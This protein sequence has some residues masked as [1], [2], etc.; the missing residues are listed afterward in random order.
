MPVPEAPYQIIGID[1]CG[2][3]IESYSGNTYLVTIV[4]WFT[5]W[6][7]CYPTKDK[8]AE[9]VA[10]LL[11]E[12]FI[13][14]FSVPNTIVS[15]NGTEYV[16]Q[17]INALSTELNVKRVTTSPYH[18]QSNGKTKRFHRVLNDM[19]AKALVGQ[20]QRNWDTYIS[21]VLLA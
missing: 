20:D 12:E 2:P 9:T 5:S 13:P 18:P 3:F 14:R 8:S 6:P 19:L 10:K 11:I 16:A 4:D 1:T 21:A 15:N 17:I 7:E